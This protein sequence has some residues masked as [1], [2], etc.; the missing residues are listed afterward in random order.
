MSFNHGSEVEV[1]VALSHIESR[2]WVQHTTDGLHIQHT[3]VE[4]S[5]SNRIMFMSLP[6]GPTEALAKR[7]GP[8]T[9]RRACSLGMAPTRPN[10]AMGVSP[11]CFCFLN[12]SSLELWDLGIPSPVA[13]RA[14]IA[15]RVRAALLLT[16]P[17]H[18]AS[19]PEPGREG[20]E[21]ATS[22]TSSYL[23]SGR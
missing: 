8:S 21:G 1:S 11:S 6:D 23:S 17:S 16:G 9:R 12:S 4:L 5:A 18:A 13:G 15:R 22:S 7:K 14:P 3:M 2:P 20:M 10:G 19:F